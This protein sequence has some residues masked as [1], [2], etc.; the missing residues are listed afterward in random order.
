M[1]KDERAGQQI[2]VRSR[3]NKLCHDGTLLTSYKDLDSLFGKEPDRR[4]DSSFILCTM[5]KDFNLINSSKD[6]FKIVVIYL[7]LLDPRQ[8]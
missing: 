1:I 7:P 2:K 3:V 4:T 8:T 6:I 5:T